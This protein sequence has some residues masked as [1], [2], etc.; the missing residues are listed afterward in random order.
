TTASL[1]RNEKHGKPGDDDRD[2]DDNG[3]TPPGQFDQVSRLGS[4]LVNEVV[5][6]LKDKDRFNGSEPKDDAQFLDY[7]TNPTLP[8]LIEALFGFAG[9]KAPTVPRSDLVA[10]FLTG[11]S[12]LTQPANVNAGEMLRLNTAVPVVAPAQQKSPGV[13]EGDTAGLP[14]GPRPCGDRL[15]ISPPAAVGVP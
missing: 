10:V 9:V 7:V 11:V 4:P 14:H 5:I 1:A 13:L 12:G 2:D 15:D 6:G 8:A 3:A